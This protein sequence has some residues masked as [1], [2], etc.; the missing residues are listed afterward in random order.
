MFINYN[1]IVRF[2]EL[3][4]QCIPYEFDFLQFYYARLSNLVKRRTFVS[5]GA[6]P[7]IC[8]NPVA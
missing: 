6:V 8:E 3:S 7:T 1:E 5:S 2:A 4:E